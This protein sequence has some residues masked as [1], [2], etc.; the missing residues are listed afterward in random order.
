MESL[1]QWVLPL[2]LIWPAVAAILTMFTS[3]EKTIKW[4]NIIAS[5]LPLGLSIYLLAAYDYAAGGMQFEVNVVW[6]ES[7]NAYFHLGVDGL[8]V[9]LLFLTGLL[10]TL[11]IYYSA[12][13]IRTRVKE[14]FVAMNIL[15]I[16]MFG[17][18]VA[19]DYVLFYLF[20]E[21]MLIPLFV[22]IALWGGEQ[23]RQAA[24]KFFLY[25]LAGSLA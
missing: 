12:G 25:A 7:L 15:A 2:L 9:P 24:L 3:N 1:N 4:G 16:S 19:L 13:T 23:R 6:I 14:Y 11:S 21:I 8:S 20:W 10:M 22:M 18:F 5:L 17:V